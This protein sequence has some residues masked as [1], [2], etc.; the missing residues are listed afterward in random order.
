MDESPE[1]RGSP[2]TDSMRVVPCGCSSCEVRDGG[3]VSYY[4]TEA[5]CLGPWMVLEGSPARLL[6][7]Q[8]PTQEAAEE[9]AR[10]QAGARLH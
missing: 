2:M 10:N 7:C 1:L 8:F 6:G 5:L 9:W 3:F 4:Q